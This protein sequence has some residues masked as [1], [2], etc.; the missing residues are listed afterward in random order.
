L[1]TLPAPA[2]PA[3]TR[4]L[5]Q[6]LLVGYVRPHV[7]AILLGVVAMGLA[8]A[9]TAANAWLMQPVLDDV[10]VRRDATMLYLIPLAVIASAFV[11]GAGTYAQA[12]LMTRVGQRILTQVQT[13]LFGHLMR[14]DLA[15]FHDTPTGGLISRFTNDVGLMR[16]AITQSLTGIAKDMLTVV[17]LVALMF[18]QDWEMALIA[19]VA[20]PLAVFP[21]LRIGRRLRKVSTNTQAEVGFLAS[22]LEETFQGARHVKAY[23]MEA[24]ETARATTVIENLYRLTMK[25]TRTRSA[26]HPI[27]ET[28][29]SFAIALVILYGGGRVVAGS[30]TPG[31]FFSFITALLL[32]YQPV[33]NLANLNANLQEGL[34]AAARVFA[35]LDLEPQIRNRPGA[36]PLA[37][38]PGEIR[39]EDVQFS[40]AP[41]KQA[42][43]GISLV[44]PA[45]RTVA[46]VG[47]SGGGKTTLL[48]LIPRFY[49]VERGR[50]LIDGS[51]VR[52]VTL[53]SLRSRIAIVSQEVSLFHDTV[54]AN[55]AYGRADASDADIRRAAALASAAE[56]IEAL[57]QGYDTLVGERGTKLSGGQR[58]RIAIARALL[59][60]APILLL[61]EATSALDNESERAVQA[62]LATLMQGRTTLVVAHR[63]STIADADL[64]YVVE[65]GRI[66]EHGRHAELVARGRTYA[67]LYALQGAESGAGEAARA[68]A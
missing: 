43:Q 50:V 56:F 46:L 23:G 45:G 19:F 17:F 7:G 2:A 33:K 34:A 11:K 41:D 29:G 63:L 18:Y 20:F 68:R 15:F 8:A 27:M 62:A 52:D 42:L 3:S 6:R 9:A 21:I 60:N 37:A 57:P 24:Y 22:L 30:T 40:Y 36:V 53:E 48:N 31:V 14:A 13:E 44:V 54:R 51:D 65:G 67:R 5:V 55:I 64:I 61:D 26:T 12:M 39:F 25:A 16:S 38:G 58:Q 28:L 10:F 66:I 47:P 49:D 1:S 59:K 32:A 35:L 4:T